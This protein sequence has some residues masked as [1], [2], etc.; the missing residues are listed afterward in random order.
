MIDPIRDD[1]AAQSGE[2][3]P[4]PEGHCQHLIDC[5]PLLRC[6][7]PE[8]DEMHDPSGPRGHHPFQPDALE[9]EDDWCADFIDNVLGG[10]F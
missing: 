3:A 10:E 7:C 1:N 9:A 2:I 4:A 8:D 5:G 6:G